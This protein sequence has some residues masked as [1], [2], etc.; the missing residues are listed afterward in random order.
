MSREC[1]SVLTKQLGVTKKGNM[2]VFESST[3]KQYIDVTPLL[4][5]MGRNHEEEDQYRLL[6]NTSTRQFF[7]Q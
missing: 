4:M 3:G 6:N 1:V 7:R 2:R 5:D